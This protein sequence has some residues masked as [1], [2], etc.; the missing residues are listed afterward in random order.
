MVEHRTVAPTAGGSIPLVHPSIILRRMRR[1]VLL[2]VLLL[3]SCNGSPSPVADAGPDSPPP[4]AHPPADAGPLP[5]A[6]DFT[7]ENCPQ[8]DPTVPSCTGMAPFTV[9]FAPI[10]TTTVSQYRWQFGDDLSFYNPSVAPS[11]TF[12]TPGSFDVTLWVFGS[13]GAQATRKRP[14]YIIVLANGMGAPCQTDQQCA[15]NLR[16]LCSAASCTTGPLGGMCTSSCQK[17]D[18]PVGNVCANLATA[19]T[20]SG[21]AEPW[22]SQL[23][24]PGCSSDKDCTGGFRCRTLPGWPRTTS[25]VHGCFADVPADLGGPCL[26]A[27]GVRRN[28]LCVTGLCADLGA[29]GLC[30]R[31]CTSALCPVGSDC[32]VFGDGRQLCLVRCSSSFLCNQDP[33]LTCVGPGS[34]LLGFQLSTPP[35]LGEE[36]QYCAPKNCSENTECGATGLCRK[37]S[38]GGHCVARSQ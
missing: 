15:P 10:V 25:W 27:T 13:A 14:G 22:Q 7:V 35:S 21:Q 30:S 4:D 16:C 26:D 9:Q 24:L 20:N 8:F 31:D 5:L 1:R 37:D 33:L 28:D 38:G 29:L 11:H 2:P 36:G 23:C 3:A 17:S 6:V 12:E 19:A 34:S 32:A 18:C